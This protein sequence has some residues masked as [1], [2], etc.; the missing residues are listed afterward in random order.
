MRVMRDPVRFTAPMQ[1][2]TNGGKF[3]YLTICNNSFV[4][5]EIVTY[6]GSQTFRMYHQPGSTDMSTEPGTDGTLQPG[7][8]APLWQWAADGT[9]DKIMY[10][11]IAG[12]PGI[13]ECRIEI[14]GAHANETSWTKFWDQ[15]FTTQTFETVNGWQALILSIYNNGFTFPSS[16]TDRIRNIVFARGATPLPCPQSPV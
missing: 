10:H 7:G 1:A 13:N 9:W 3:S 12:R 4:T 15:T 16:Y 11:L 5:Q 2:V 8:V 6:S 14:Y